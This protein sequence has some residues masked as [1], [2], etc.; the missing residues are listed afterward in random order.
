MAFEVTMES[1]QQAINE[2][3][4][5]LAQ[6]GSQLTAIEKT[7]VKQEERITSALKRIDEQTKLTESIHEL[8]T[9]VKVLTVEQKSMMEK[10]DS[11]NK[12][13]E[14]VSNDVEELKQKPAKRWDGVVT[15]I[16]S[17][18]IGGLLT[19]LLMKLGLK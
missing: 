18:I 7:M 13:I 9:S 12:K 2:V 17:G 16:I 5:T 10:I 15:V 3:K 8:A 6:H 1:M 11:T 14:S 4:E 19:F